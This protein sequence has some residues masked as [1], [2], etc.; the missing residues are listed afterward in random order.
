MIV[1]PKIRS[2]ICINAHPAGCAKDTV[3]QI[4]YVKAQKAKRGIK[5]YKEGGKGP[6]TVLVLGCST[7]YGLASRIA[8]SFEYG[9]DTIGV[10]FEKEGTETRG[11]TPGFYNN[12]AFDREAKAAGLKSVTIN[13]DA[14]SNEVR[15]QVIDEIKKL[16]KKID[17]LVYSLASPVRTD[18]ET[19]VMY[20]SVIKPIGKPYSGKCL[21][22]IQEKLTEASAEPA[23]EEEM[24]NT[25]KVMGGEDWKL[26]IDA[27]TKAD[28]LSEGICTVAYSYIGPELSHAIYR[29]GTI[30]GAKKHLE[31]TARELDAQ[32]K[33]SLGGRAYVSENKGL[34][35]RSSA[36]IPVISLY[37]AVLFKVMKE[38][39]LH[40]GCIEQMERLF[41]E[42]LYTGADS[43]MA[44]IPVDSENR[45]R[46]DDWELR[47]DVQSKA[48]ANMNATTDDNLAQYCDLAGYKHDFLAANGFDVEGIDYS[49]DVERFDV[50]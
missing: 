47:E 27:L 2:N 6:A 34:V 25:V 16:G 50:I 10:S 31:K 32:L 8:A 13:G 4:E 40:E 29:D 12:M 11:G 14:Y 46:L 39:N 15:Q 49:K 36:V 1:E 7:G 20:K 35:T 44:D 48:V 30:G 18:P 21:D 33:S 45:I 38:M 42:R 3:R 23:T 26:W 41:A 43:Q 19:K 24:A 17:L 5:T 28:C 9:A 37:L 22:I